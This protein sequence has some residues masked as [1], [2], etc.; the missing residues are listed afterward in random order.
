MK[1]IDDEVTSSEKLD[2]AGQSISIVPI[3]NGSCNEEEIRTL[4]KLQLKMATSSI[5]HEYARMEFESVGNMQR[6]EELLDFMNDCRS[7][8]YEAREVLVQRDPSALAEFERDLLLQ[9]A[10]TLTQYNA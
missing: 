5:N 10:Q 4:L 6:R 3:T 7:E 9:K 8:Y 1:F 2:V